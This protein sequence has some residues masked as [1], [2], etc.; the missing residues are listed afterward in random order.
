MP[1]AGARLDDVRVTVGADRAAAVGTAGLL[2]FSSSA[3][4]ADSVRRRRSRAGPNH[5]AQDEE[6]GDAEDEE[7]RHPHDVSVSA[8]LV[9]LMRSSGGRRRAGGRRAAPGLLPGFRRSGRRPLVCRRPREPGGRIAREKA[10]E[11]PFV[12]QSLTN[13]RLFVIEGLSRRIVDA[14]RHLTQHPCQMAG[15]AI[16]GWRL[17]RSLT[18]RR[19]ISILLEI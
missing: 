3:A 19:H 17:R 4:G 14:R 18:A 16:G 11:L 12:Q 6:R 10:R 5:G 1:A 13:E 15:V 9:P 7:P 2:R 8:D